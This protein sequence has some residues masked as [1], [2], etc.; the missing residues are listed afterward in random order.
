MPRKPKRPC[1][2]PGC[3]KLTEGRFCEEHERQENRRYEK[4]T[5]SCHWQRAGRMTRR[6]SCRC[7][8][9]AMRGFMRSAVTGGGKDDDEIYTRLSRLLCR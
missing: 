7:A 5:I 3:P 6:T 8:S 1:S 9:P 2:F 4:Y